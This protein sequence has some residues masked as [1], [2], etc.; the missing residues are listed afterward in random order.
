MI[1]KGN[2]MEKIYKTL[3]E[4]HNIKKEILKSKVNHRKKEKKTGENPKH[5]RHRRCPSVKLS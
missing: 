2:E 1:M 4:I 3:L 5:V